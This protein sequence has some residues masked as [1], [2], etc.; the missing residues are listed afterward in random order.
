MQ[1]KKGTLPLLISCLS[2]PWL[3][4]GDPYKDGQE[5]RLKAHL[6]IITALACALEALGCARF[7]Q[8]RSLLFD[9]NCCHR[10]QNNKLIFSGP[11]WL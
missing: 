9:H 2:L 7:L 1:D 6:V 11:Q 8:G 3:I 5:S 10:D 4:L